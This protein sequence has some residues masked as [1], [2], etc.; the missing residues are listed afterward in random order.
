MGIFRQNW[1]IIFT[2][3]KGNIKINTGEVSATGYVGYG[4][5]RIVRFLRPL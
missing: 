4:A 2:L 1:S 5:L 3:P